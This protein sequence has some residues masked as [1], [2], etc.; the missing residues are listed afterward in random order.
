MKKYFWVLGMWNIFDLNNLLLYVRMIFCKFYYCL[1]V[2]DRILE[3]II[4]G[5]VR[6][7]LNLKVVYKIIKF[8]I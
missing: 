2:V 6:R 5:R 1:V 3:L 4:M 7:Y 8:Y